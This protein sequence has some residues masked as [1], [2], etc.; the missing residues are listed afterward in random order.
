LYIQHPLLIFCLAKNVPNIYFELFFPLKI[1]FKLQKVWKI[2]SEPFSQGQKSNFQS[3][4]RVL[5]GGRRE[6]FINVFISIKGHIQTKM[7]L[8]FV[9]TMDP[10]G[11]QNWAIILQ[12]LVRTDIHV[13]CEKN[14]P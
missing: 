1:I 2:H 12:H 9:T 4:K 13:G 10:V 5:G 3:D 14:L 6:I 7:G 11:G 8:Y